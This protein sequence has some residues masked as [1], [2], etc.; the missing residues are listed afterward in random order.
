M[1]SK[2]KKEKRYMRHK[3]IRARIFGRALKPRLY[4]FKS[5]KHIYAQL[6]DDE[7]GKIIIATNDKEIKKKNLPQRHTRRRGEK[8]IKEVARA[9]KTALAHD[10]GKLIAKKALE[11][12]IEKIVFDR[13]GYQISWQSESIG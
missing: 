6:I 12:K 7:K 4:V 9:G 10:V 2:F 1:E 3:R 13:G 8:E 5:A 11:K